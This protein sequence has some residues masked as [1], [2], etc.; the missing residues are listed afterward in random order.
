MPSTT[1]GLSDDTPG[2]PSAENDWVEGNGEECRCWKTGN[3]TRVR[4]TV[5]GVVTSGLEGEP[6]DDEEE[7]GE[8]E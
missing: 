5:G 2:G 1:G 4:S 8:V 6:E 3:G 7:A